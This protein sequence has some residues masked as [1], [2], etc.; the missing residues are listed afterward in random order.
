[1]LQLEIFHKAAFNEFSPQDK[2]TRMFYLE[3]TVGEVMS[4]TDFFHFSMK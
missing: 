1:M 3:R 2:T 4:E